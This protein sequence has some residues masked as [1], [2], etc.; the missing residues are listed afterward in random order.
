MPADIKGMQARFECLKQDRSGWEP[1]WKDLRDYI[2][3]DMGCFTGEDVHQGGKRYQRLFDAEA[4]NATDILA[5]GLL[6][7]VSSPSR[8]WLRLTTMD[9]DLDQ[10]PDVKQWLSA[11][12]DVMLMQ[13]AK[14]ESYNAL[15][16][17]YLE[18]PVFG[19]ACSIVQRHPKKVL[20]LS[21]LTVGEYW[22]ADD[23]FGRVDTMYRRLSMTAKQMAQSFGVDALPDSVRTM[24][25][26]NP[27]HR[28]DVV[29]AIEPRIERDI[30][31]HDGINKPY[32]S[33]YF[34]E[35]YPE[36]PL[37]EGGFDDFPVLA[38]RWITTA[39]SVYGRG[40]GAKALSA[41]KALQRLQM[42][43]G[44]LAD[45]LSDPPVQYPANMRMQ[46]QNF[47]PG[48]RIAVEPNEVEAMRTAWDVRA[49]PTV[50]QSLIQMRKEEIR[51]YFYVNIFQMI[52]ATQ[53]GERTAT[54][55]AALE[56]EK[57][58]MLGPVLERLHTELLDPLVTNCF[59]FMVEKDLVPAPPEELQG[60]E[61][62]VEYISVLAEQQKNSAVNGIVR[63]VQQIGMIA[64]LK[65][66][67]LDKLDV[68]TTIDLL[69]DMNS[70]PP[71]M[72][73]AGNKVA[74]VRD[75]R[76]AQEQ[77]AMQ[78][79]QGLAAAQGLKDLAQ[80]SASVPPE[81]QE[82]LASALQES[83]YDAGQ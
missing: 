37:S 5:A 78:Q 10:S 19:T 74:M 16:R 36:K 56:Q 77:A 45:Y 4:A 31:K 15:H 62:N 32:A 52:A 14:S 39:G 46:L 53:A 29:H 33:V 70:V 1:L 83:G 21:N 58:M 47:R 67:A 6:G 17:S 80:A 30:M 73:V 72:I 7:G 34:L 13:F 69:A 64:Q 82:I 75:D 26:S 12:Q 71:S 23:P 81:Q 57:V 68:D 35:A 43:L 3:P 38:P 41:S 66:E 60:K 2:L 24:L 22:L 18:L 9:A 49:D 51:S 59:N 27:F 20:D 44:I 28:F 50:V 54:E 63:T 55:V 79:Q 76:N 11:V 48:G 25:R 61:L 65:P 8:P 42:R 40:P